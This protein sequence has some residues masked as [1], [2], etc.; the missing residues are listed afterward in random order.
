MLPSLL[1]KRYCFTCSLLLEN[2]VLL[3]FKGMSFLGPKPSHSGAL[4][5]TKQFLYFDT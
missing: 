2:S 3:L 5:L 1:Q 4:F